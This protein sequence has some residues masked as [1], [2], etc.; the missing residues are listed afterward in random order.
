MTSRG[1]TRPAPIVPAVMAAALLLIPGGVSAADWTPSAR[2]TSEPGS[3]LDS[4]HQLAAGGG[5]LHLVHPR[6]GPAATDD[7]ISYQRSGDAGRRWSVER[8]IFRAGTRHRHV[9]PNLALAARGARVAVVWRVRGPHGTTLFLRTSDDGG[10]T[11]RP[12]L[13]LA[14]RSADAAIGVPAV[15]IGD[16]FMAVAWTDRRDG[17][18][19]VRTSRDG[20]RSFSAARTLGRSRL[21]IVC[22]RD[23]LDG[24]VGLAAAGTRLHVAWSAAE[25]G[26]CIASRILTRS[27]GDRGVTWRRARTLTARSS[28]GW[29]ELTARGRFVLA[30]LQLTNGRLLLARSR[31]SGRSWEG[32]VLQPRTG[33]WLGSGDVS[34]STDGRAWTVY[35][36]ERYAGDELARTRLMARRSRDA[37]RTWSRAR[38]IVPDRARLRQSPNL[39]LAGGDP[40]VVFQAG[41]LS[42]AS[43]DLYVTRRSDR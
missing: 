29:P 8:T 37:G 16:G 30:S 31:D 1:W 14:S 41:S 7:R 34:L 13:A 23:V 33:R 20:G 42:G 26:S 15:A 17:S 32:R 21:S 35:V 10:A 11:F 18:V 9:M 24:L 3:R 25:P 38:E 28:Y 6:I 12:R 27:S 22:R 40:V 36:D 43:R 5:R 2:V 19:K 4:L 39:A